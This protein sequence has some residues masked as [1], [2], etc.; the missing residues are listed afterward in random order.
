MNRPAPD[1][2]LLAFD[3][4]SPWGAHR[5]RGLAGAWLRF[6]H[7][8]PPIPGGRRLALWARNPLKHRLRGPVDA[9]VWGCR[10]R[11]LPRGNLSESRWLFMPRFL[12]R[13]ERR[14]WQ[15][16]LQRGQTFIDVGANAGVYSFWAA[17]CVGADGRVFAVEPDADM[18]KRIRFNTQQNGL[19]NL[20][21][22]ACALGETHTTGTLVLG[23]RN[24]GQNRLL[25]GSSEQA[26]TRANE[27]T[28]TVP[29]KT[30]L[31]ICEEHSINRIDGL[32]IDIE[33]HE[34][35]VMQHF[36]SHA[37]PQ[38]FP[39]LIQFEKCTAEQAASMQTLVEAH[40][41]ELV[42]S[43]RMNAIYARDMSG[44]AA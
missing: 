13:A 27:Q 6:C 12:D 15:R 11:L 2:A 14:F 18:R 26:G 32:K 23:E 8:I 9:Q 37:S 24:R 43:G 35:A 34:H 20:Q 10:M 38:Q 16:H 30:L 29:V 17:R 33:G 3:D 19:N 7:A 40:G 4:A 42:C 1:N 41:Y 44:D 31:A 21:L 28:V 39:A 25:D 36:F 22:L 5:L